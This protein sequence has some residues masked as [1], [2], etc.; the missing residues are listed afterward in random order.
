MEG[1]EEC[2]GENGGLNKKKKEQKRG[3]VCEIHLLIKSSSFVGVPFPCL[4]VPPL[5]FIELNLEFF[6]SRS[7]STE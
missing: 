5:T 7:F 2:G 3:K 4:S 1:E 6:M